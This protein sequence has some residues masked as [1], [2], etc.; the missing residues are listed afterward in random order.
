[1]A[2]GVSAQKRDDRRRG[3]AVNFK[4]ETDIHR[5][6]SHETTAKRHEQNATYGKLENATINLK[7]K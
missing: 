6:A 7:Q 5:T 2:L 4:E 3:P 1:M